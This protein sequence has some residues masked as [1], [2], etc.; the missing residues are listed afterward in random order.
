M[1]SELPEKFHLAGHSRGGF[2]AGLYAS[3]YP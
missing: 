3:H 1:G 2:M